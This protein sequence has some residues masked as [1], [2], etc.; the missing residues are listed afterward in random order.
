MGR[1]SN[2]DVMR[3]RGDLLDRVIR[4]RRIEISALASE[5]GTS[6]MTVH[7]DLDAL[8]AERLLRKEHGHAVAPTELER[9]TSAAFR[10]RFGTDVKEAVGRAALPWLTAARTVLVDDSTSCLPAL[11]ARCRTGVPVTVVTN[12]LAVPEELRRYPHAT[13]HLVG[14]RVAPELRAV[15]GPVAE[16]GFTEWRGDVALIS[17]PGVAG[18][19]VLHLLEDSARV[20]QVIAERCQTRVLLVDRHKLGLHGP[21][22]VLPAGRVDVLISDEPDPGG[23]AELDAFGQA[24]TTV[25]TVPHPG[26][27]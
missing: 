15:F 16:A 8:A 22:V 18:G 3:R 23:R 19:E 6:V 24:G 11:H 14:G 9:Q 13:V 27:D 2:A 7:R 12:F 21:H 20:K 5:L 10:L 26:A 4:A 1:S 25:V 17:A